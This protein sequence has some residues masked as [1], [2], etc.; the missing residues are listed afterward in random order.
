MDW[1]LS[2]FDTVITTSAEQAGEL[3]RDREHAHTAVLGLWKPRTSSTTRTAVG[4]VWSVTRADMLAETGE[5]LVRSVVPP[6]HT[7]SWAQTLS[8]VDRSHY[9]ATGE[10]LQLALELETGRTPHVPVSRDVERALKQGADG[11]PRAA[12][13]GLAFRSRRE[14]VPSEE[15]PDWAV[16]KLGRNGIDVRS[17]SVLRAGRVHLARRRTVHPVAT[18]SVSGVVSDAVAY[19]QALRQGVGKGKAFGLGLVREQSTTGA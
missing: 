2:V 15:L 11:T 13:K 18:L 14:A 3:H 8:T 6:E 5:V 9:A 12:G 7:P 10:V 4:A 19:Q 17:V 1:S 16:A